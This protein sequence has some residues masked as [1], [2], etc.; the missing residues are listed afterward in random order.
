M[1]A[2]HKTKPQQQQDKHWGHLAKKN[3]LGM[4]Q[5]AQFN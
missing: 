2:I 4:G 5:A 1:S 3:E